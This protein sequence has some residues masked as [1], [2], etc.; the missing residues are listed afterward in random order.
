MSP[1]STTTS[2]GSPVV[3][4]HAWRLEVSGMS[5]AIT[6][7]KATMIEG[8]KIKGDPWVDEGDN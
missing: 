5:V 4:N 2:L 7:G 8:E 3:Q 1:T 6:G